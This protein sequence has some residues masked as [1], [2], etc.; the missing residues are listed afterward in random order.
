MEA[1]VG[2]DKAVDDQGESKEVFTMM[3][4]KS[5][6]SRA[7]ARD[8]N[9]SGEHHQYLSENFQIHKKSQ[10]LIL[11]KMGRC[12]CSL[13][14]AITSGTARKRHEVVRTN[15][16]QTGIKLCTERQKQKEPPHVLCPNT[17]C[18]STEF[19]SSSVGRRPHFTVALLSIFTLD[20]RWES[21]PRAPPREN[22]Q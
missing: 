11:T 14:V 15:P 22:P 4:G 21:Q 9:Y 5:G 16:T 12:S 20:F 7:M 6:A 13:A 17:K 8:R 1:R 18:H 10:I 19:P 3:E 2:S